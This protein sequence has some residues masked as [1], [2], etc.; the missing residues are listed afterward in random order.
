M[1]LTE[2]K[3]C[4][5]STSCTLREAVS[6]AIGIADRENCIVAFEFNT[7]PMHIY[8]FTT[9]SEA[10]D[11]YDRLFEKRKEK[12]DPQDEKMKVEPERKETMKFEKFADTH[13]LLLKIL[14]YGPPLIEKTCCVVFFNDL[15]FSGWSLE[16]CAGVGDTLREAIEHYKKVISGKKMVYK[17]YTKSERKEITVPI[18]I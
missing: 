8:K 16:K 18:L 11:D 14:T 1:N 13:G 5:I 7:I 17:K 10:L 2:I 4:E 12:K 9:V 6:E 15:K 3:Q